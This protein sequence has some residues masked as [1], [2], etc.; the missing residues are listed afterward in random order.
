MV[1][2]SQHSIPVRLF[3]TRRNSYNVNTPRRTVTYPPSQEIRNRSIPTAF[4]RNTNSHAAA[5]NTT[6]N[7]VTRGT[8]MCSSPSILVT[9]SAAPR[10][11]DIIRLKLSLPKTLPARLSSSP[12]VI[13]PLR[14][15]VSMNAPAIACSGAAFTHAPEY[16]GRNGSRSRLLR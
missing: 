14:A 3:R 7:A 10:M 1:R 8:A 15:R 13:T 9:S 16:S 12:N 5:M 11:R 2:V 6:T 4:L